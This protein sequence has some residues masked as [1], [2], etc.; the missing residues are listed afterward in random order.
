MSDN[1]DSVMQFPCHFPIKIIGKNNDT[2]V[3]DIINIARGHFAHLKDSDIRIQASQKDNYVAITVTVLA[4][5][6]ASLDT[7]YGE[8][9]KHPDA[10]MVL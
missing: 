10:K 3:T 5:D 7:L 2:F 6:Q 4:L 1:T 8:L 9:T